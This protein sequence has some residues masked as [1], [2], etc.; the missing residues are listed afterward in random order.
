MRQLHPVDSLSNGWARAEDQRACAPSQP[1]GNHTFVL[2]TSNPRVR[3]AD[4]ALTSAFRGVAKGLSPT[5]RRC[6]HLHR[7]PSR[8]IG[9]SSGSI[10]HTSKH[11]GGPPQ[12]DGAS[13]RSI[14]LAHE[15]AE[16]GK[17]TSAM[18]ANA[19]GTRTG[20]AEVASKPS[21]VPTNMPGAR[22]GE[23][24]PDHR[25]V[26]A[27]PLAATSSAECNEPAD[28]ARSEQ[29][30]SAKAPEAGEPATVAVEEAVRG[31]RGRAVRSTG[32]P[33]PGQRHER[34]AAEGTVRVPYYRRRPHRGG[35]VGE[36]R[37]AGA[38]A[39]GGAARSATPRGVTTSTKWSGW[40]R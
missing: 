11:I 16:C 29:I 18:R 4:T 35:R 19:S 15:E 13:S 17:N 33:Q 6:M 23:F 1:P 38:H 3:I 14:G 5:E 22:R 8:R 2:A 39:A 12:L 30:M 37:A 9:A 31:C 25:F 32:G 21:V 40:W 36:G 24:P 10:G 34:Q 26:F 7:A 20:D 28:C 27:S